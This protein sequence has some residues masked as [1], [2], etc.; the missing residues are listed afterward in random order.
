VHV[1][2]SSTVR[3]LRAVPRFTISLPVHL[4]WRVAG[5]PDQ[6][7]QAWTKDVSTRGMLVLASTGPG[8]GELLE[9]EID[10]ALDEFSPLMLVQGEG[11]VVRV[12]RPSIASSF[13]GFAVRNS[14][15]KLREP[16]AGEALPVATP[17]QSGAAA[18]PVARI[19]ERDWLRRFRS[20][21]PDTKPFP[22]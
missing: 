19:D 13:T 17:A 11:R 9:F 2:K 18:K 5:R 10:M 8:L 20:A 6:Q 4:C 12:E 16:S 14:W 15:F 22:D 21:R 3:E 1:V 7:I